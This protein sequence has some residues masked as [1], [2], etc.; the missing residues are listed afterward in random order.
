MPGQDAVNEERLERGEPAG[1]VRC[2][3]YPLADLIGEPPKHVG[4]LHVDAYQLGGRHPEQG[5]RPQRSKRELNPG[6]PPLMG[7]Q[8]GGGV[9]PAEQEIVR[10]GGL[11]RVRV[12]GD[13]QRLVERHDHRQPGR[14]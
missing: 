8:R 12:L 4:C 3:Q 14:R 9:Q 1:P 6:L 2:G 7:D 13:N 5:T 10:A 11:A